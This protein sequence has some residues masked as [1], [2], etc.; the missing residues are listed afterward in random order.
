MKNWFKKEI[1][2]NYKERLKIAFPKS[3]ESD[4][5]VVLDIIPFDENR[6]KLCDGNTHIVGDLIHESFYSTILDSAEL[7]IPIRLYF[8]EPNHKREKTLTEKQQAILNCIYLR[9]HNGYLRQKRLEKLKGLNYYWI[10]PFRIQLLGEYV[11]EIYETLA[12]QLNGEILDSCKRFFAENPEFAKKTK[13]RIISYY[14]IYYRWEYPIFKN[15]LAKEIFD[16]INQKHIGVNQEEITQIGIDAENRLFVKPPKKIF[17]MVDRLAKGINWDNKEK[18]LYSSTIREWSNYKW[19]LYILNTIYQ[20]CN[21]E[22]IP[23]KKTEYINLDRKAKNQIQ[24][25]KKRPHSRVDG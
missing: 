11:Y 3:L 12:N 4:L 16:K 6:V 19:Y 25:N 5:N 20:E 14:G 17:S 2:V 10:T 18:V 24:Q 21:I 15:Y 9:H 13:D 1:F 7:K 22:L 8:N 23:T